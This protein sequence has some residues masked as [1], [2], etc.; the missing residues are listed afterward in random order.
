MRYYLL[1][2]TLLT[3]GYAN[4][5]DSTA[6]DSLLQQ[7]QQQSKVNFSEQTGSALWQKE[8]LSANGMRRSC[9]SCHTQNLTVIGKHVKTQ[10]II[11]PLAPSVNSTRLTKVKTIKK[12][13]KRNC[14]WTLG[15]ECTPQEKGHL[16][17]FINSQ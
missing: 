9:S 15:R 3:S 16:L 4:A 8:F 1:G 6:V 13:F 14:K 10:K 11:K 7:Y 5:G 12:W 2:L 17:T